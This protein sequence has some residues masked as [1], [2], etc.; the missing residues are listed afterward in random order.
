MAITLASN[1]GANTPD[2]VALAAT[3]REY[4]ALTKSNPELSLPSIDE[5]LEPAREYR[6]GGDGSVTLN[7]AIITTAKLVDSAVTTA[8]IADSA[9]TN[10]KIAAGTIALDKLAFELAAGVASTSASTPDTVVS[11]N[12]A[13]SF[14]THSIELSDSYG[15]L[16]LTG[17]G[18]VIRLGAAPLIHARD[19][20]NSNTNMFA[21]ANAA[22]TNL[23]TLTGLHNVGVGNTALQ[24]LTSGRHNIAIGSGS[25]KKTTSSARCIGIG[26][27]AG[28][29]LGTSDNIA[30]G[31]NALSN[32]NTGSCNVAIGSRTLSSIPSAG[33]VCIGNYAGARGD[34]Y[35]NVIIGVLACGN[36]KDIGETNIIMGYQAAQTADTPNEN[37]IIG[38]DAGKLLDHPSRN[39]IIGHQALSNASASDWQVAI[40]YQALQYNTLGQGNTAVGYAALNV[41][42]EG[43]N[44]TVIG[45]QVMGMNTTGAHNVA[46]GSAS[47][48]RNTTGGDNV[49]IGNNTLNHNETNSKSTAVGT[50]A[51]TNSTGA[52]NI[53]LGYY[54]GSHIGAGAN[55]IHIGHVGAIGDAK[56]IRMGTTNT[57]TACF[58]A[59][60][61]GR[62]V[63]GGTAV[64]INNAGQLG[65]VVSSLAAKEDITP[66]NIATV[67]KFLSLEPVAFT[68]TKE[69]DS[70]H[71]QQY[72]LIADDVAQQ[73]SE[74]ALFDDQGQPTS[75]RYNLLAPLALAALKQQRSK[76]Q[77]LDTRVMALEAALASIIKD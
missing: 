13:G 10:A 4:I 26:A 59:G 21:G 25:L 28:T 60:I 56:V 48:L 68:Y 64:Y 41:N 24:A 6:A 20:N 50:N 8:K 17:T 63:T 18:D 43:N 2:P 62:T 77:V 72:G 42:T 54:A 3:L 9:V 76:I 61:N 16:R 33:N 46:I 37:V 57:S 29:S 65:T 30:L 58:I 69:L 22:G 35:K 75:V 51:L 52:S 1:V 38:A 27:F 70:T 5:L 66:I 71:E 53:A 34:S 40:G 45:N 7:N 47:L 49:G 23:Y 73:F 36:T 32:N 15:C 12:A 44:N 74:L 11:R 67:N 14:Q 31:Y 39:V 19:G 55:N